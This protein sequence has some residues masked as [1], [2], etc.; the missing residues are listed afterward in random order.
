VGTA[1]GTLSATDADAGDTFTYALVSGTGST[2]NASFV[3]D[4]GTLRTATP[5]NFEAGNSF[6]VRVRAT[7]AR[8]LFA[9]KP[10]T[11]AVTNVNE[12][13]TDITL[14]PATIAENNAVGAVVGAFA[15]ADVDAG[16][17]FT[18]ALA[19][20]PGDADNGSFQ[21]V[22]NQLKANAS[23]NFEARSSYTVRVRSTDQGGLATEKAFTIAVTDVVEPATAPTVAVPVGFTVLED[24]PTGLVF[25]GTPFADA[26]SPAAKVMT[27]TLS[28]ADGVIAATTAG[29]VTVAGTAVARTFSGT[30]SALNA[31]FTASPA[32]I[33]Y[34]PKLNNTAARTLTTRISE[35][36]GT[37]TLFSTATT[38]ITITPVNDAPVVSAP[39]TFTVTEDVK[40][41]LAWPAALTP[42]AD[43]DSP[44]LTVT[45]AVADGTI[46]AASTAAVTVGGTA[47]ARTFTGSPTG[48][49]AYFKTLGAIGYTTAQ[50]NTVARTLTTT[51]FDGS[52][53]ASA[54]TQISITPVNDA[55]TI[56]PAAKLGGGRVGTAFEITYA[57]LRAALNVADVETASP[58]ILIT[59]VDAGTV[60]KWNGTSWVNVSTAATSA[61]AQRTLSVGEKIR[62]VPPAGVSGDRA[63][64]KVKARDGA[65]N[66]AVTAQV[67][68]N[69]A[70]A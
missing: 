35:I 68:I 13:P 9:E 31:F 42:F 58:S 10:F 17:A 19:A 21:V 1:V 6:S 63:G 43:V 29:G 3:I 2:D 15:T 16:E 37:G 59:A 56:N 46:T 53:S 20:G 4:G 66:S 62:W 38:P 28:V 8:G 34:R 40:G 44:S 67:T 23:F 25:T 52:L 64:F 60:Q 54:S 50:D 27:V 11:V 26:D 36:N 55:P 30:R 49:N 48:L 12:V 33:T 39:A 14:T 41:N 65:L 70:P 51:V 32:R 61:L 45:L 5:F 18:Y 47:T 24:T 69:L 7:D 22:G 57:A